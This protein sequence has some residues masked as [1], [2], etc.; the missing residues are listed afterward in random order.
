MKTMMK[1]RMMMR[2]RKKKKMMM[3]MRLLLFGCYC[4]YCLNCF[5]RCLLLW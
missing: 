1:K 3:M 2:K 4:Y 5:V